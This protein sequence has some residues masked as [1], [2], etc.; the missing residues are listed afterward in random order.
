MITGIYGLNSKHCAPNEIRTIA[1]LIVK[2]LCG[3]GLPYPW[4]IRASTGWTEQKNKVPSMLL[5]SL[6]ILN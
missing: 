5:E 2:H 4:P 6:Q 1:P 3:L